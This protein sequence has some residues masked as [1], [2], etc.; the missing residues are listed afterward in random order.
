MSVDEWYLT[1]NGYF[2][3]S[4]AGILTGT[5]HIT[6]RYCERSRCKSC[7]ICECLKIERDLS[8]LNKY[9]NS[10]LMSKSDSSLEV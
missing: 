7:K 9:E 6:L 5:L 3:L 4:L 1:F 10:N 8:E 2:W